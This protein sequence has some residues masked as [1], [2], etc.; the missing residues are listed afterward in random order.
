VQSIYGHVR[1]A[2]LTTGNYNT[3]TSRP[4]LFNTGTANHLFFFR[5]SF[6]D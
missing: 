2:L 4:M 1:A 6:S 5:L 3:Q